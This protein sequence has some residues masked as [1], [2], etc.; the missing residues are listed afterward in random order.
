MS[1]LQE[2]SSSYVAGL[3]DL[4]ASC[5]S[6]VAADPSGSRVLEAFLDS[7]FP[8]KVKQKLL[9]KLSDHYASIAATGS[10]NFLIEKIYASGVRCV[11]KSDMQYNLLYSTL[12]RLSTSWANDKAHKDDL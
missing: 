5:L 10:G 1:L 6:Q 3:L 4:N 12:R 11:L 7:P 2:A 9:S 8:G